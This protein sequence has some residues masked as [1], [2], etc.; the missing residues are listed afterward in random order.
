MVHTHTR[1]FRRFLR[2]LGGY[3]K[4][5]KECP[6]HDLPA[7]WPVP[8]PM[9]SR[10]QQLGGPRAGRTQFRGQTRCGGPPRPPCP[11]RVTVPGEEPTAGH[12]LQDGRPDPGQVRPNRTGTVPPRRTREPVCRPAGH[13]G[14]DLALTSR[15]VRSSVLRL[16]PTVHGDGDNEF[17]KAVVGI[18]RDNGVS[19]LPRARHPG[20]QHAHPRPGRLAAIWPG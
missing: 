20:I 10:G 19:G 8:R 14:A 4:C 9:S 11:R 18:A 3:L 16:P 7:S 1:P 2:E 13:H 5:S 17:M 6:D 15:G 12:R